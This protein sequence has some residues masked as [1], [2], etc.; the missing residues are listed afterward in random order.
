M[1]NISTK[2]I[3]ADNPFIDQ[4]ALTIASILVQIEARVDL[5]STKKRDLKSALRSMCRLINKQPEEVPANI[6]WVHIRLRRVQPAAHDITKKRLANI[7]SD[8]LKALEMTGCSRNRSDWLRKPSPEWQTLL[9]KIPDKHDRW[10]L[11]Q[12]AQYC[13]ALDVVPDQVADGH[14][15]GLLETLRLETFAD[16]PDQVAVYAAKTWNRLKDQIEDWP[17][18]ELSRPPLKKEPWTI[19]LE[20]FP[21]NFQ[22]D[23]D[24]WLDHLANPD[25]LSSDGPL[26]PLRPVT[27]KHRH[28]QIQQMCSALV[29]AGHSIEAITSL[30]YLVDIQNFKDGVR[31]LMNRFGDKPTEAI[32]GLTIER[33]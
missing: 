14:I 25:P 21:E 10:K 15:L 5:T 2:F 13:S 4:E 32:H 31:Q 33:Q 7:K 30:A 16:K 26:K 22:A 23:V 27:I 1:S 3:P 12:L 29:L 6:N 18:I 28:H 17:D 11:S 9:N 8:V 20:Q 19:P 24:S